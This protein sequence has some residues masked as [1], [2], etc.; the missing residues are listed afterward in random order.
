[1][2]LDVSLC[3]KRWTSY[4]EGK[5]WEEDEESVYSA[6]ITHNLG[7]MAEKLREFPEFHS[8]KRE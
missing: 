7:K 1:M 3:V 6:N 8:K 5:T 4:D 2:S